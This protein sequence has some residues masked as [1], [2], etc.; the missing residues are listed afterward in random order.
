M[1]ESKKKILF[2]THGTGIYGSERCMLDLLKKLDRSKYVPIVMIKSEGPLSQEL[3]RLDIEI[4]IYPIKNWIAFPEEFSRWHFREVFFDMPKRLRFIGNVIEEKKIAL[5]YTNSMV[6][7]DGALAAKLKRIPHIMH[8]HEILKGEPFYRPYMP[9]WLVHKLVRFLSAQVL[10]ES[11]AEKKAILGDRVDENKKLHVVPNA[12]DCE[13]FTVQSDDARAY[14]YRAEINVKKDVKLVGIIAR[15]VDSK[16]QRDFIDAAKIVIDSYANVCFA[17]I[18]G[19]D[20]NLLSQYKRQVEDAGIAR[21]VVFSELRKNIVPVIRSLDVLVSAS[22]IEPFGLTIIEAMALGKPV[23]ATRCGGPGETV[24]D[25]QTG[26]LV[27]I[28]SPA[29]MAVR[30]LK[31]LNDQKLAE[32]MGA[33]GQARALKNYNV[34]LYGEKIIAIINEVIEV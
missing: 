11:L 2:V 28:K 17:I 6:V 14:D 13:R 23:V 4:I 26:F 25:G 22:R 21:Q 10:V 1:P 33:K 24:V 16:G 15:I 29:E 7:I 19:G 12:V 32:E 5:V 31:L 27:P 20:K 9:I 34:N 8:I 18:G 3:E 30:I